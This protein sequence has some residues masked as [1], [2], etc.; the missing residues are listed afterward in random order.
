VPSAGRFSVPRRGSGASWV[1]VAVGAVC[2]VFAVALG[3]ACGGGG[4]GAGLADLPGEKLP[5][6][7]LV[8]TDADPAWSPNGE[9]IVFT[10]GDRN[11]IDGNFSI[12][13]VDLRTG[14]ET[15]LTQGTGHWDRDPV[16]SP[17]QRTITFTRST[18]SLFCNEDD[19]VL[20]LDATKQATRAEPR[21]IGSGCVPAWSP[22]GSK[23]AFIRN[24]EL[25][26]STPTGTNQF[27]AVPRAPTQ[28]RGRVWIPG[29]VF[30]FDWSPDGSGLALERNN[31][32]WIVRPDGGNLHRI[33]RSG[34]GRVAHGPSWSPDGALMRLS[35]S[36]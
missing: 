23:I 15:A 12:R 31:E 32:I 27:V 16:W 24:G 7:R 14:R 1:T 3:S 25:V 26:I 9:R 34:D 30:D 11:S 6:G 35:R 18:D 10:R 2:V 8:S 20:S 21:V 17:D 36:S 28:H 13:W 29:E 5:T 22:D 33:T 4:G 19:L